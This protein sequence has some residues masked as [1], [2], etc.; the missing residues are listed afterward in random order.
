[1]EERKRELVGLI[2]KQQD[3]KLKRVRGLIRRHGD[4]LE[5]AATLVETAIRCMEE[6]HMSLFIEVGGGLDQS[7]DWTDGGGARIVKG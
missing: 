5:A 1:M 2:A 6:P 7:R 3:D 4:E